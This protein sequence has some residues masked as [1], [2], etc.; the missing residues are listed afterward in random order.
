MSS[1]IFFFSFSFFFSVSLFAASELEQHYEQKVDESRATTD[2]TASEEFVKALQSGSGS[3]LIDTVKSKCEAKLSA[4]NSN[5]TARNAGTVD[6]TLAGFDQ[7][8]QEAFQADGSIG[9]NDMLKAAE[10]FGFIVETTDSKGQTG[11]VTKGG[12]P[13]ESTKLYYKVVKDLSEQLK[14]GL[15]GANYR[16]DFKNG[17][18]N[19]VG[20]QDFFALYQSQLAKNLLLETSSFCL[21]NYVVKVSNGD[22]NATLSDTA[23][24]R[25]Q[26]VIEKM[27]A[28]TAP[29]GNNQAGADYQKCVVHLKFFCYCN[30]PQGNQAIQDLGKTCIKKGDPNT[31]I[32]DE[33]IHQSYLANLITNSSTGISTVQAKTMLGQL[34][35]NSCPLVNK[36]EEYSLFVDDLTNKRDIMKKKMG[37]ERG[38]FRAANKQIY[39]SGANGNTK[40]IEKITTITSK[41]MKDLSKDIAKQN[42]DAMSECVQKQDQATCEKIIQIA[43]G[44][45]LN[46][47]YLEAKVK[48]DL[49]QQLLDKSTDESE[50]KKVL[51]AFDEKSVA[52]I[53]QIIASAVDLDEIKGR[54]KKQFELETESIKSNIRKK[55]EN[56][57]VRKQDFNDPAVARRLNNIKD[58]VESEGDRLEKLIQYNNLISSF[59]EISNDQTGTKENFGV[60]AEEELPLAEES[61][62][63]RGDNYEGLFQQIQ[64]EIGQNLQNSSAN[65]GG[66]LK[67]NDFLNTI[68]QQDA[69]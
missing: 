49:I 47:L 60:L 2:N 26:K 45:N 4:A 56:V 29:G 42:T 48:G 15:Y 36:L 17:K 31:G 62:S 35:T 50:L 57:E 37:S 5:A 7:C 23:S 46:D 22:I 63:A 59:V 32:A 55:M 61:F 43:D 25:Y 44:K 9:T 54:F 28:P 69:P 64:T 14:K 39:Q 30:H 8:V 10:A 33:P 52:E 1:F 67:A 34:K 19:I 21:E 58:G 51:L 12:Q 6:K 24:D 11:Y 41:K 53:D 66:G 38:G 20:Q 13:L 68:L 40:T 65:S 27:A 3:G 18:L 16:D